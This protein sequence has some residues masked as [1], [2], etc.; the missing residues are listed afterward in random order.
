M[1]TSV[2]LRCHNF[3]RRRYNNVCGYR[4]MPIFISNLYHNFRLN[5][6]ICPYSV[7]LSLFISRP[8]GLIVFYNYFVW[9]CP[10]VEVI[11]LYLRIM[12]LHTMRHTSTTDLLFHL[13]AASPSA[14]HLAWYPVLGA[15]LRTGE[16]VCQ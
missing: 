7:F 5:Q 11:W 4:P 10:C 9:C 14:G 1:I 13:T 2:N 16:A 15:L 12:H 8:I 3:T 6:F